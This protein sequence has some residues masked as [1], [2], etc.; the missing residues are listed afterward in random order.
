M[1]QPLH[2]LREFFSNKKYAAWR[3]LVYG[4]ASTFLL[5]VIVNLSVFAVAKFRIDPFWE[6]FERGRIVKIG[7]TVL[8][9]GHGTWETDTNNI[10]RHVTIASYRG[11]DLHMPTLDLVRSL[12]EEGATWIWGTWCYAGD[13]SYVERDLVTGKEVPWP[14]YVSRSKGAGVVYPVWLVL[15]FVRFTDGKKIEPRALLLDEM[16]LDTVPVPFYMSD[17]NQETP[18]GLQKRVEEHAG[19]Y[20]RDRG[21]YRLRPDSIMTAS[22]IHRDTVIYTTANPHGA[23]RSRQENQ[24]YLNDFTKRKNTATKTIQ[25]IMWVRKETIPIWLRLDPYILTID[26]SNSEDSLGT[27]E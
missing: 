7:Q 17:A 16:A 1:G 26:T 2:R 19:L 15:G 8:I 20:L 21:F 5:V 23:P 11:K 9:F 27:K 22:G 3:R 10:E 24:D 14:S 4:L 12:H 18:E 6:E 25:A 13:R